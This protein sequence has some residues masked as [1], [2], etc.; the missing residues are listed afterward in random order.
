MDYLAST[1]SGGFDQTVLLKKLTDF[2][3]GWQVQNWG[4]NE[5]EEWH[6]TGNLLDIL[7]TVKTKWGSIL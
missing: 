5:G 6:P 7:G 3:V 2:E 1:T 4:M